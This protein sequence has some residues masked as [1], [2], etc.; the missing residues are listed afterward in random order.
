M[1]SSDFFKHTRKIYSEH[2]FPTYWTH[3]T[4]SYLKSHW[5]QLENNYFKKL[6]WM[7]IYVSGGE[8]ATP[9]SVFSLTENIP[10]N[11]K[12]FLIVKALTINMI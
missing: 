11:N 10:P 12:Y 6:P 7:K 5:K 8:E 9:S 3:Y 1:F 4:V 2:N